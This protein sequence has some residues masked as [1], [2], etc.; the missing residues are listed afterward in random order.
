MN[1]LRA[2]GR[3]RRPAAV[4]GVGRRNDGCYNGTIVVLLRKEFV[5]TGEHDLESRVAVLER[6]VDELK[7]KIGAAHDMAS[8]LKQIGTVTDQEAFLQAME[9]GKEIRHSDRP[10]ADPG[11]K[12]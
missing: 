9:Y 7:S 5:M 11:D 3:D 6:T 8:W 1:D 4:S 10:S 2:S 12:S